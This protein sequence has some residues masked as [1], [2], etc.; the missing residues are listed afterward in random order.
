MEV[1]D[2]RQPTRA[3]NCCTL[4]SFAEPFVWICLWELRECSS[5]FVCLFDCFLDSIAGLV[6]TSQPTSYSAD[7]AT[8]QDCL[9]DLHD[10]YNNMNA[11]GVHHQKLV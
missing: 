1:R 5:P 4:S 10:D 8:P 7:L 3:P 11:M 6:Q 9:L 2:L